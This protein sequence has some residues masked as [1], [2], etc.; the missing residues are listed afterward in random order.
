MKKGGISDSWLTARR[1]LSILVALAKE[2]LT[3]EVLR[4]K[5]GMTKCHYVNSILRNLRARGLV[6]CLNPQDKIG[7]IFC[8]P[9]QYKRRVQRVFRHAG[10]TQD[11]IS[12]PAINWSAYGRLLCSYCRQVRNVFAKIE[13][14]CHE[15]KTITVSRLR[16]RLPGMATSDIYRATDK[17]IGL[18]LIKR[19]GSM[20]FV[21]SVTHEGEAIIA[22]KKKLPQQRL[23]NSFIN[24]FVA[25]PEWK[26]RHTGLLNLNTR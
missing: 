22:F 11:V 8:I 3:P 13:E 18:K 7:K 20:P 25:T 6:K 9:H 4:E 10:I 23:P 15:N 2:P 26:M 21:F 5:T 19:S 1:V 16:E 24:E 14:L 12:L 17:L